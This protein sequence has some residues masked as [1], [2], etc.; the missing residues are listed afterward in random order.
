MFTKSIILIKHNYNFDMLCKYSYAAY[1]NMTK[2]TLI[3]YELCGKKNNISTNSD[4]L[5][6]KWME[7]WNIDS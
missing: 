7:I 6:L 5:L 2:H 4:V 3:S 1:R